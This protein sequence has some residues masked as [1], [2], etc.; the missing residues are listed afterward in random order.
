MLLSGGGFSSL[1]NAWCQMKKIVK[2][3]TTTTRATAVKFRTDDDLTFIV[4]WVQSGMFNCQNKLCH[5]HFATTWAAIQR[6]CLTNAT[7]SDK[8]AMKIPPSISHSYGMKT[9]C[10]CSASSLFLF[11][12]ELSCR[13]N[14]SDRYSNIPPAICSNIHRALN[15]MS[16]SFLMV[17][18]PDLTSP[19]TKHLSTPRP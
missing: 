7:K 16:S 12:T 10:C 14:I 2:V 18:W 1:S 17:N 15:S 6:V 4:G 19:P 5:Q 8:N 13:L 9:C 11:D 3:T